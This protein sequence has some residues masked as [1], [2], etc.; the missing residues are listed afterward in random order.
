[1]QMVTASRLSRVKGVATEGREVTR[2]LM[3]IRVQALIAGK[4]HKIRRT[5][6]TKGTTG[7]T[8]CNKVQGTVHPSLCHLK[9][10]LAI[11]RK[12]TMHECKESTV[13]DAVHPESF[14]ESAVV[15]FFC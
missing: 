6:G 1:M 3:Q 12:Q 14:D 9:L 4:L 2:I 10:S 7:T 11:E 5:K 15:K 8:K 13:L